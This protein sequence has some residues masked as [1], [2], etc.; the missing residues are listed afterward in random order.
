MSAQGPIA[1]L[2]YRNYTGPKGHKGAR[3]WP[4]TKYGIRTSFRKKAFWVLAFFAFMPYVVTIFLLFLKGAA[5]TDAKLPFLGEFAPMLAGAY[6]NGFWPFMMA[7]LIGAGSIAADNR[8][9]ALQ[10]YLAKPITKQDYLLGKWLYIFVV[11]FAIYFVPMFLTTAYAGF[12]EG[13]SGFI[14]R[15]PMIFPKL[16]LL[17]AIP[18]CVHA[19]ILVGISA[20]NKTPWLV[21]VVYA[22]IWTVTV[23]FSLILGH[24]LPSNADPSTVA[25]LAHLS[26]EGAIRGLGAIIL[27]ATPQQFGDF[28]FSQKQALP[29]ALP[30]ILLLAILAVVGVAM[31]RMRIRAVEVVQG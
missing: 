4:I 21:G 9:N 19:S 5:P 1:D 7:L 6:S 2:S 30:L 8:A 14:S 16:I 29:H 26:I 3:W 28:S 22:A 31:A 12:S 25:T 20:W 13:F 15:N 23:T 11:V 18:A 17:A 27:G 24:T 10:V